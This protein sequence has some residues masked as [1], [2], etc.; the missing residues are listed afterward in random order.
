MVENNELLNL[1][2]EEMSQINGGE[3][4][5]Y[6]VGIYV[7]IGSRRTWAEAAIVTGVF[8]MQ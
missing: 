6:Y 1:T 7:S 5:W 2:H 4:I 3:S 8:L